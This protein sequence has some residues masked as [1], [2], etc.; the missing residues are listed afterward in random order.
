MGTIELYE[1]E[2]CPYCVKVKQK[3]DELGLDYESHYVP[4]AHSDRE[5][6]REVSGQSE[7]P[8]IVDQDH[9][10][11]GMNESDDIVRYLERTYGDATAG[12]GT[13]E[14]ESEGESGGSGG[15]VGEIVEGEETTGT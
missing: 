5:E 8:V 14:G 9:G 7:V 12:A 2:G 10:V 15:G 6:V 13:G 4:A 3:L 11:E 1:L